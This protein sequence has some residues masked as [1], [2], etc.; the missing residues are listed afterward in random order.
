MIGG[1]ILLVVAAGVFASTVA[2]MHELSKD[3]YCAADTAAESRA[4]RLSF[5]RQRKIFEPDLF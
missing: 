3:G 5:R 4:R 2:D 1:M